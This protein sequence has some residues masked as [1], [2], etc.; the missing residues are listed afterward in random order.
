MKRLNSG[1]YFHKLYNRKEHFPFEG[2]FELTYRCNFECVHCYCKGSEPE[3]INPKQNELDTS[4]VKNILNEIKKEGCLFIVF[5]GG[6]PFLRD[7]F[8]EIYSHARNLGLLVTI[9]TNGYLLNKKII[10]FLVNQPPLSIE[11]TLNGISK[12]THELVT[13][14]KGSFERV[15]DAIKLLA[16][17]NIRLRLKSNCLR[18]NKH[19][20]AG[21]NK[22]T[23][24]VLGRPNNKAFYF[25]YDPIIHARLNGDR[26]VLKFGL[27][28][29]EMFE[30][31]KQDP[32]IWEEYQRQTHCDFPQ[33]N[34]DGNYLYHCNN[35]MQ[36]F[37]INP[38][39][40]LKFCS[41][42]DKFSVDLK[43]ASFR[44]GFYSVFPRLLDEKFKTD[45]K[46]RS[47]RLRPI[48]YYC[49]ARAFLDTGNE[50]GPV[51]LYCSLAEADSRNMKGSHF[52]QTKIKLL[53]V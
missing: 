23:Q 17:S 1:Y 8:L 49:P 6:E 14:V 38:Y 25:R 42:S 48:C 47:C 20:I 43:H 24:D 52:K 39:G 22:F 28:T 18:Q 46:C 51:P 41:L 53:S 37:F 33:L 3:N 10:N 21:I 35:W 31:K 4:Q 34:R 19:E 44:E 12:K 13:G 11:I 40:R 27:S 15:I 16:K 2:Q 30:T 29:E 9:F 26:S 7:D 5:T 36:K 45:S 32:D 50:E